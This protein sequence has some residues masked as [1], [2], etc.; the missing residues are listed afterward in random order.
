MRTSW[1]YGRQFYGIPRSHIQR[2]VRSW[3]SW[4]RFVT[5]Q[6]EWVIGDFQV[7]S[8]F[9]SYLFSKCHPRRCIYKNK[10]MHVVRLSYDPEGL[11]LK[12]IVYIVLLGFTSFN[13]IQ[14]Y[15]LSR[16]VHVRPHRLT[17]APPQALPPSTT[18]SWE[19]FQL[20]CCLTVSPH[21]QPQCWGS[22]P[23]G[24]TAFDSPSK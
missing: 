22:P 6:R 21:C 13:S 7:N 17:P 16:E 19:M 23:L 5:T 8:P 20:N 10:E 4:N 3:M 2:F 14:R 12:N 24:Q 11:P 1:V 15:S 9:A 18:V